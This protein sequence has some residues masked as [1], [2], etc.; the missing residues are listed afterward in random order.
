MKVCSIEECTG[1]H[2]GHGYCG[3]H[4]QRFKKHGD[5]LICFPKGICCIDGCDREFLANG[6]CS[7]HYGRW[8]RHGDPLFLKQYPDTCTVDGCS[9]PHAQKGFCTLHYDR[10]RVHGDPLKTK[11]QRNHS[12]L[13]EY[14]QNNYVINELTECWEWQGSLRKGYGWMSVKRHAMSA[15][16]FSY[17]HFVGEIPDELFVCHVCDNRRCC[18]PKHLFIGTHEDNMKDMVIKGRHHSRKNQ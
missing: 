18:N 1:R 4:Y 13:L 3:K 16:R 15:H 10:N 11:Y 14:F 5:P 9:R 7:L 6:Y 17:S 2:K 8:K 12:S